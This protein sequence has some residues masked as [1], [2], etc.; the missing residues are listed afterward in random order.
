MEK[1]HRARINHR[2]TEL[3]NLN[4]DALKN[5]NARQS[6]LEKSDI[7]QMIAKHLQQLPRQQA[8]RSIVSDNSLT[9]KF[10]TDFQECAT[11][12]GHY[13]GRLAGVDGTVRQPVMA[14]LAFKVSEG[15]TPPPSA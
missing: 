1:H 8:A 7:L 15:S 6:K 13:L 2:L 14:H 12:V 10:C 4:L 11:E 3:K 5:G 9:D